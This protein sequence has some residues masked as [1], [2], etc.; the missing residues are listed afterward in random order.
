MDSA[1]ALD[2]ENPRYRREAI[3]LALSRVHDPQTDWPARLEIFRNFIEQADEFY[4]KYPD[5]RQPFLFSH[6]PIGS[7]Y[8]LPV[9][10]ATEEERRQLSELFDRIR[11]Y[12]LREIQ[13]GDFTRKYLDLSDG[14]GSEKELFAYDELIRNSSS[15]ERYYDM[16]KLIR[17][18]YQR[19]L[20][21]Y[22]A[23][24]DFLR[25][26]PEARKK[27]LHIS[28][29]FLEFRT[30]DDGFRRTEAIEELKKIFSDFSE[31]TALIREIDYPAATQLYDQWIAFGDL[32]KSDCSY[33]A[34]KQ[35][36]FRHYD[37]LGELFPDPMIQ[38]PLGNTI[39]A[40]HYW[41]QDRYLYEKMQL[42]RREYRV[43]HSDQDCC[44]RLLRD[45]SLQT[46]TGNFERIARFAPEL[47]KSVLKVICSNEL[48][49]GFDSMA[50]QLFREEPSLPGSEKNVLS[51][52]GLNG[53]E[54]SGG[55]NVRPQGPEALLKKK[56]LLGDLNRAFRI[57]QIPFLGGMCM[58]A[59]NLDGVIY[60]FLDGGRQ[61][62]HIERFD[63]KTMTSERLAGSELSVRDFSAGSSRLDRPLSFSALN[64]FLMVGGRDAVALYNLKTRQWTQIGD[65]PGNYVVSAAIVNGRCYCLQ[66][67]GTRPGGGKEL[68]SM[69]SLELDGSNR[70]LH[71]S[72][73]RADKVTPLDSL[74][75]G[76]VTDLIVLPD[77]K[78]MFGTV[79]FGKTATLW[80][81]DPRTER[82][83]SLHSFENT[84]DMLLRDQGDF[85]LGTC[86]GFGERFF[87]FDKESGKIAWFLTQSKHDAKWAKANGVR[88]INGWQ[89]LKPP[90]L[91][92]GDYLISAA[93]W[94]CPL[95]LDLKNPEESPLLLVPGG[96][97]IF[98]LEDGS[99]VFVG[100]KQLSVV[101]LK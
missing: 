19:E 3:L 92:D 55:V 4:R 71:F 45:L 78:L 65:L 83:E 63:P 41:T 77:G 76:M 64:G 67:G 10:R 28:D 20:E 23:L 18:T 61:L 11:V 21:F 14:V 32:M 98:R 75:K 73:L 100:Q 87:K 7:F 49:H 44:E 39:S 81:F 88:Q 89:E 5:Y 37:R 22:R 80:S 43:S 51:M 26:H 25:K 72:A 70:K 42:I 9:S 99:W 68:L 86:S 38:Y 57:H 62:L 29:I 66:G 6:F 53:L 46:S 50:M 85:V 33:E 17:D 60:L 69:C 13:E 2:P 54:A 58:D 84:C 97:G 101:K 48:H 96:V 12:L 24:R 36:M 40:F 1:C 94:S 35:I 95:V 93:S 52:M 91:L 90:L 8:N 15:Y 27:K 79:I 47:R 34:L 59:V 74:P 82:F 31:M 16:V 56:K 30:D